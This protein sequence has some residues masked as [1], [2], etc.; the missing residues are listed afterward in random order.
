MLDTEGLRS[1]I[2]PGPCPHPRPCLL[3]RERK[4]ETICILERVLRRKTV[5]Q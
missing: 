1:E 2:R 4:L 3:V 5:V